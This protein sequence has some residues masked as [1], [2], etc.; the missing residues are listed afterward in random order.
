MSRHGLQAVFLIS[1]VVL[2]AADVDPLG[3]KKHLTPPPRLNPPIFVSNSSTTISIR[4]TPQH[5]TAARR[6]SARAARRSVAGGPLRPLYDSL[7]QT[8]ED[9][10]RRNYTA[11]ACG[12][13]RCTPSRSHRP[14]RSALRVERH[15]RVYDDA[16]GADGLVCRAARR[17]AEWRHAR[18]RPR[19]RP[20][21]WLRVHVQVW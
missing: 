1:F 9:P 18:H 13:T 8:S 15:C 10:M 6:C 4:W 20:R 3:D 5:A 19:R 12:Q 16:G 2:L 14:T 21:V 17:T 7:A 11:R